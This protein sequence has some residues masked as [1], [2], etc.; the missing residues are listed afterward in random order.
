MSFS[1]IKSTQCSYNSL[2]NTLL[3]YHCAI[4]IV[5]IDTVVAKNAEKHKITITL[6]AF[7]I[8][9]FTTSYISREIW[10]KNVEKERVK[11]KMI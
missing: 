6:T 10:G 4:F 5:I 2:K 9:L 8:H 1:T 3:A 7:F 11:D